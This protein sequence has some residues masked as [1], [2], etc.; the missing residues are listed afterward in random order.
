ME[1]RNRSNYGNQTNFYSPLSA[2][3]VWSFELPLR[4]NVDATFNIFMP[5]FYFKKMI[6][7]L[8][9]SDDKHKKEEFRFNEFF[10]CYL[11]VNLFCIWYA[12]SHLL[13]ALQ[14]RPFQEFLIILDCLRRLRFADNSVESF[15]LS[16][17]Q[18]DVM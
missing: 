16:E 10:T 2:I 14:C 8:T 4:L 13:D 12:I 3:W 17:V 1:T 15:N 7:W 5:C 11:R 9:I 18:F 6:I